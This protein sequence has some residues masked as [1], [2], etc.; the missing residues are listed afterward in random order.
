MLVLVFLFFFVL[1][2]LKLSV[3]QEPIVRGKMWGRRLWLR[4]A[5]VYCSRAW[6]SFS[7]FPPFYTPCSILIIS[8]DFPLIHLTVLLCFIF[9]SFVWFLSTTCLRSISHWPL[10]M[11]IRRLCSYLLS[12]IHLNLHIIIIHIFNCTNTR[13]TMYYIC[14]QLFSYFPISANKSHHIKKLVSIDS[15]NPS[16]QLWRRS[17]IQLTFLSA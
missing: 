14:A 16:E 5:I 17:S 10:T 2:F 11:A 9:G 12:L 1:Y 13:S 7:R 15:D 3:G 4:S 8:F 6:L